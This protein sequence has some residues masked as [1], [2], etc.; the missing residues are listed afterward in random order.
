MGSNYWYNN[1]GGKRCAVLAELQLLDPVQIS[2]AITS[3]FGGNGA[4]ACYN[5]GVIEVASVI[6][7]II[8]IVIIY[9]S[10]NNK[11]KK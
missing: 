4:Q 11:S 9:A 1:P 10:M 8:G 2:T 6:A 5:S 3:I 7:A